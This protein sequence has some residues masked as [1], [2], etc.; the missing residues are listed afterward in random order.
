MRFLASALSRLALRF[1]ISRSLPKRPSSSTL[2]SSPCQPPPRLSTS[3]STPK[4][5]PLLRLLRSLK[6]L[7]PRR[8]PPLPLASPQTTPA[9]T[10]PFPPRVL[11]L[12]DQT[13]PAAPVTA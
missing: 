10:R 3:V 13:S 2:A 6:H 4:H 5:P 7:P 9:Q 11:R 8:Q 12:P 1:P